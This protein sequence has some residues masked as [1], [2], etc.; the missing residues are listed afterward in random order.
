MY[1]SMKPGEVKG[2]V[3]SQLGFH[4]LKLE[5][6]EG[7]GSVPFEQVLAAVMDQLKLQR[8][9]ILAHNDADK[10]FAALYEEPKL[11]FEGFAKKNNLQVNN[12]GPFTET[13]DIGISGSR[14]M[15]KKAFVFSPGD[16]GDVVDADKGYLIYMVTKKE[17]A[18]V[19]DLKEITDKVTS[20]IKNVQA[21]EKAKAYALRLASSGQ[22]LL[23]QKTDST[24]SF[25]RPSG[26]VPKLSMIPKLMDDLDTLDK[27]KVYT[28][29]GIS[30]IVWIKSK[31]T[32][33]IRAMDKKT[34]DSIAAELLNQK[35][36]VFMEAYLQ[37][38][39]KDH[40][41]EKNEEKLAEKTRGTRHGSAP[42]DF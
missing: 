28:S 3:K 32:A 10:A 35:R 9:K 7:G 16:L 6:K 36:Q 14:E 41:V 21:A 8:A 25:T 38:A 27:P 15:L 12:I 22:D 11:D 20:D 26:S 18:R 39:R 33:D 29:K 2:P 24:G 5:S 23:A 34:S 17:P 19:P 30:Y 40:K 4:I 42:D 1:D 37:Q 31:Q 13:D